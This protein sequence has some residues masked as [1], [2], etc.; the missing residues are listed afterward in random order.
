MDNKYNE[1]SL[2]IN[3]NK[4]KYKNICLLWE[5]YIEIKKNKFEKELL[6]GINKLKLLNNI[7]N[8]FS[9]QEII[10]LTVLSQISI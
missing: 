5:K 8:D 3:N 7:E 10:T 1:F 2:L 4:E 6:I 9:L